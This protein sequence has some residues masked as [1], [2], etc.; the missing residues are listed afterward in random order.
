MKERILRVALGIGIFMT[1]RLGFDTRCNSTSLLT[2]IPGRRELISSAR[3]IVT[4]MSLGSSYWSP[5]SAFS[6]SRL[7]ETRPQIAVVMAQIRLKKART[8]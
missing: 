4:D 1:R 7:Y 3:P 5:P 2:K 6:T 8:I